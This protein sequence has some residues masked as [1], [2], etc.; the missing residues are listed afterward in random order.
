MFLMPCCM[1]DNG[2]AMQCNALLCWFLFVAPG[3][4]WVIDSSRQYELIWQICMM[5][6]LYTNW[7]WTYKKISWTSS[8][9][10]YRGVFADRWDDQRTSSSFISRHVYP[11]VIDRATESFQ[12]PLEAD[13]C[14]FLW[15]KLNTMDSTISMMMYW[16]SRARVWSYVKEVHHVMKLSSAGLMEL[17]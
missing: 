5:M 4:A 8:T 15:S 16:T 12:S 7:V 14:N 13:F 3:C 1:I 11:E 10:D 17:S 2:A 9:L 6:Q